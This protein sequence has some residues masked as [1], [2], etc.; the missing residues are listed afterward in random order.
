MLKKIHHFFPNFKI[1][2]LP[3]SPVIIFE[4]LKP[5]DSWS[6]SR[7]PNEKA[8][9]YLKTLKKAISVLTDAKVA[10]MD[11]R[12]S[13]IM[14]R[15]NQEKQKIEIKI[16]DFEDAVIFGEKIRFIERLKY[17]VMHR[18]PLMNTKER[19]YA[20]SYH[21]DWFFHSIQLW[22]IDKNSNLGFESFMLSNHL[23]VEEIVTALEQ[24]ARVIPSMF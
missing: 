15:W 23:K 20:S 1:D 16:I 6:N 8:T 9:K 12:P 3:R 10:H 2:D 4:H 13:N 5:T 24:S 19:E 22:L 21:N 14:W 7:P 18:Y 11:L 17:D